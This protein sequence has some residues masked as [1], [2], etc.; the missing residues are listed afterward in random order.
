[1]VEIY[2]PERFAAMERGAKTEKVFT[3]T[4][5]VVRG[6]SDTAS[7][8]LSAADEALSGGIP[9]TPQGWAAR[10]VSG[11]ADLYNK[12]RAGNEAVRE[13]IAKMLTQSGVD[14][15]EELITRIAA[16]VSMEAKR[17]RAIQR[18]AAGTAGATLAREF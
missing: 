3:G 15:N 8:A 16:Q 13:Q 5:R 6:G 9:T 1:M 2:G 4:D 14:A 12:G 11:A 17:G 10:F 7:K 18:S